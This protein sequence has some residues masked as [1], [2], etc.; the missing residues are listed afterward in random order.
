MSEMIDSGFYN[1]IKTI[2]SAARNK[3]YAAANNAM[4]EAYWSIGKSIVERQGG[5]ARAEYGAQLI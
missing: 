2:L 4:V 5:E 1:H 3:A